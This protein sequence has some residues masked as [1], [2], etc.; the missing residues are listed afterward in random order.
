M[1]RVEIREIGAGDWRTL[2]DIR[3]AALQDAPQA[4]ASTYEREAAF[5]EADW[6]RWI[7]RG[8]TFL[9]YP[10]EL[11]AAPVGIVSGHEGEPGTIEL[12]SMWTSPGARGHG[13]GRALVEAVLGRA[14][15]KGMA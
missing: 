13:T 15:G 9:A 6:L 5:A 3:L 14:R 12:V 10:P 1:L 7:S 4:F 8:D 2:R 11:G